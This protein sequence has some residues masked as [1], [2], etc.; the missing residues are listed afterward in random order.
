MQATNSALRALTRVVSVGALAALVAPG[1]CSRQPA[2]AQANGGG[3]GGRGG[4]ATP[5]QVAAVARIDAP[6]DVSGSGI[7]S[8]MQTVAVTAQV[9][10]A[11]LDV[12]F[13]E[14]DVVHQGQP[15]FRIDPRPLQDAVDQQKAILARDEAQSEAGRREDVRYQT[16][17]SEDFVSREQADQIHATA[18]AQQA[19]VVADRAALRTAEVNL[20]F[21]TVHAPISG[22]TGGLLVRRGNIIAPNTGALVVIDQLQPILVRFPV[23]A[24]DR[25]LLQGAVVAHPLLVTAVKSDSS[26]F[27]ENGQ[28]TFVDNQADSLTGMILGKAQLQNR[29]NSFW[30]G[31]LVFLTIHVGVQRGVLAVPTAAVLTGQQGTYVYVVNTAKGTANDRPVT[32]GRTIGDST[33]IDRGVMVGELVIVDGQSRLNPGSK[34]AIIRPSGDSSGVR[35]GQTGRGGASAQAGGEVAPKANGAARG[36]ATRSP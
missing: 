21:S 9:S 28:L 3:R 35:L 1:A 18:L 8:P 7:V 27:R 12:L 14:G 34:V 33:I 30:P 17:V 29:A 26:G 5:V 15:L 36:G 20:G 6:I 25:G 11:L 19:T 16:L 24:Q 4:G 10:G 32:V 22:R 2:D 13:K 23:L 31:D